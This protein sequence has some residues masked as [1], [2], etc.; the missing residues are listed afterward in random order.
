MIG[1][2]IFDGLLTLMILGLALGAVLARDL[3][4]SVVLFIIYGLFIAVAWTQ[5]DA[6]DV[7]LAEAAIG[8]GLTGV[9]LISASARLTPP[10]PRSRRVMRL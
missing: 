6:L 7:A 9:L 2:L 10:P 1:A 4:A 5:L 3:F 8:A